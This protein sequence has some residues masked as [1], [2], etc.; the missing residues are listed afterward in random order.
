ME[1]Y[2]LLDDATNHASASANARQASAVSGSVEG[3]QGSG[4]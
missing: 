3:K 1:S 4:M 2:E